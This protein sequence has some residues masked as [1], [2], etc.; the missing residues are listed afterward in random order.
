MIAALIVFFCFNSDLIAQQPDKTTLAT[1]SVGIIDWPPFGWIE[2]GK[3][4]GLAERPGMGHLRKRMRVWTEKIFLIFDHIFSY[5]I[6]NSP[7]SR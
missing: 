1:P 6:R 7:D 3:A 4:K 5:K 2:K